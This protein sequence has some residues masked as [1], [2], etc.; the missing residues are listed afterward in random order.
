V[1]EDDQGETRTTIAPPDVADER[2][3]AWLARVWPDLSRARIQGLI[4]AGKLSADGATVTHAKNKPRAGARYAL[5]L[6]PPEPAAPQPE[7]IP[8]KIVFEDAHLLV[9][10]KAA[11]MAMHPAPGSMRGTL[12][13][14]VLAH[15][16]ASLSGIGGVARPGIVHRIDKDTTGLV[17]VAKSD[18][19]HN[20]LAALFA[21]H[22][23]ERVYYA[24]TRGAPK[25]RAA[26]IENVLVRSSE[27]RR[28]YVVA[29]DRDASAGKRAITQYWTIETFGQALGA[30][31][32]RPAAALIECRLFTGRT[33]QIRAHLSHL[34]AP[35]IG[36]PLYGKQRA[37]KAEGPHA[38]EVATCVA[39]FPRQALHAAVLGFK[40]PITGQELRFESEMP[41]DMQSL[42]TSLR[43]L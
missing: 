19:A 1:N 15:C 40:H 32:G 17:V 30:S 41:A 6:P 21:K 24:L 16:G 25:E 31:A 9:I 34:G 13:N 5:V 28:K 38:E 23:L 43:R 3:D 11:G 42:L 27:D 35:L 22:D 18:A 33:H 29:R 2:V 37:F 36:D 4:G 8:L 12:V 10:D 20:G 7:A 14:A 39:A 26:R